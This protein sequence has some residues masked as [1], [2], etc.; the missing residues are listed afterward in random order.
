MSSI[1]I[2]I[3]LITLGLF[4]YYFL[5]FFNR[6]LNPFEEEFMID[7]LLPGHYLYLEI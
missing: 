6:V 1:S 7:C 3:K 2:F 5:L 4:N